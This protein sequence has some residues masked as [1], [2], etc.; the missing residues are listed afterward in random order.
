M[1][2]YLLAVAMG[3]A[4][5]GVGGLA[6]CGGDDATN[7]DT[8]DA[9]ADATTNPDVTTQPD[10]GGGGD[11]GSD[12][13]TNDARADATDGATTDGGTTDGATT[14]AAPSDAALD[15]SLGDG[16]AVS[17]DAGPG[18]DAGAISCGSANCNPTFQACCMYPINNPPPSFFAACSSGAS[19]PALASDAG[20]EAGAPVTLRCQLQAHCTGNTVCCLNAT[21][22]DVSAFCVSAGSCITTDAGVDAAPAPSRALLC[23]P[24]SSDAGCGDAG[25]CSN[26]NIGTWSLP[27]GFGTCG[28]QAR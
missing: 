21:S 9:T 4:F 14:D 16:G 26:T 10:T 6:A 2:R 7:I 22:T 11:A 12:V 8:P 18:G 17:A 5:I 13:V 3:A 25:A 19:C 15:V 27:S 28:G 1:R 23:D 20:L 24:S